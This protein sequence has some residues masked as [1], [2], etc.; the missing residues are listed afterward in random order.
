MLMSLNLTAGHPHGLS[1]QLLF[2]LFLASSS[3]LP[4]WSQ[5]G[6][7]DT[8]I[9]RLNSACGFLHCPQAPYKPFMI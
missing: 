5:K 4:T 1:P 7:S 6:H 8:E 3:L 9:S 2:Q